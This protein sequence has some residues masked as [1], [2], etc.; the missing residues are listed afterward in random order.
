MQTELIGLGFANFQIC[1]RQRCRLKSR[2][3]VACEKVKNLCRPS[4]TPASQK[5]ACRDPGTGLAYY[6]TATH[7]S[8][9]RSLTLT[10]LQ[11]GLLSFAPDGA[12]P[13]RNSG[14]LW[15]TS[16]VVTFHS[17]PMLRA[18]HSRP[19]CLHP[20]GPR[21]FCLFSVFQNFSLP[22]PLELC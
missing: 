8:R 2:V 21:D 7:P 13:H 1:A 6:S 22:N 9:F 17:K 18:A 5:R 20:S 10:H 4:T 11:S 15:G 14:L 16:I 19:C 12:G 3:G